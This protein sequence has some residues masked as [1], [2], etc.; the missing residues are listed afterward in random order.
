MQGGGDSNGWRNV[1]L[2][3]GSSSGCRRFCAQ[4]LSA[5][6]NS[7]YVQVETGGDDDVLWSFFKQLVA[8]MSE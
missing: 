6:R 2:P 4:A 5:G 7:A 3:F 8:E 1:A